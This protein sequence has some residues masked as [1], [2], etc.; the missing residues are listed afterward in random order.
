MCSIID[1]FPSLYLTVIFVSLRSTLNTL[2]GEPLFNSYSN[3]CVILSIFFKKKLGLAFCSP[4]V[5]KGLPIIPIYVI[6]L[7]IFSSI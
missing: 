5:G 6:L 2:I 1:I 4:V 3:C 7:R